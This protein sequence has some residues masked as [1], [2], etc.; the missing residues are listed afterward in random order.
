MIREIEGEVFR[1]RPHRIVIDDRHKT[2]I[3]GVQ[4]V[5][6]FDENEIV[7]LTDVGVII[8][9]GEGL[10]LSKLNLDEGQLIIDGLV[11]SLDYDDI[12]D[13]KSGLFGRFK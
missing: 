13:K 2:T 6:S 5:E 4:A 8:I 12:V 11:V 10:H 7:V 1:A 9:G 3:S